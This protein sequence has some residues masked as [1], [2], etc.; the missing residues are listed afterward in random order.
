MSPKV[1]PGLIDWFDVCP[2]ETYSSLDKLTIHPV[3]M[4]HA[5]GVYDNPSWSAG[6]NLPE[7]WVAFINDA[8]ARGQKARALAEAAPHPQHKSA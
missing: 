1:A 8:I 5:N 3:S 6:D 4:Q 7:D 2:A